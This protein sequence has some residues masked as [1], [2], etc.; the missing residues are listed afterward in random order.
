MEGQYECISFSRKSKGSFLSYSQY[1]NQCLVRIDREIVGINGGIGFL[2][3]QILNIN[4][5]MSVSAFGSDNIPIIITSSKE[6]TGNQA[7]ICT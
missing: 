7:Y 4:T 2:I 3:R 5:D 6:I 1:S